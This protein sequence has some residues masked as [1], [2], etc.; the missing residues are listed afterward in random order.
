MDNEKF[1]LFISSL[2][3]EKG[4]TQLELANKLNITDKAVSKWERGIGFPD[5]KMIE[6]LA[7]ILDVS[8]LEI[9]HS[10]KKIRMLILY[11]KIITTNSGNKKSSNS[12]SGLL[13]F[14]APSEFHKGGA[15]CHNS[16]PAGHINR[17]GPQ[18]PISSYVKKSLI[19]KALLSV[20]TKGLCPA[21]RPNRKERSSSGAAG[22][23]PVPEIFKNFRNNP[24]TGSCIDPQTNK[25]H[26][27]ETA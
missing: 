6:P 5:L 21:K 13:L 11:Q 17:S 7:E 8:I 26:C 3:K 16:F 20:L 10:E 4:W 25:D 18:I 27:R 14:C 23:A 24:E 22:S 1:G 12:I 2:R 15:V 9:M 19:Q